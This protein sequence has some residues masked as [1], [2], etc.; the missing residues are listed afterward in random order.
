MIDVVLAAT[1]SEVLA[2][3]YLKEKASVVAGFAVL[4][5]AGGLAGAGA[6]SLLKSSKKDT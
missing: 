3:N 1:L 2:T 6:V 4:I 5:V